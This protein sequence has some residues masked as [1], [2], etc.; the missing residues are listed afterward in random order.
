MGLKTAM[1]HG[2]KV[3][4]KRISKGHIEIVYE[5]IELLQGETPITHCIL[6]NCVDILINS[7]ND[8]ANQEMAT[9]LLDQ[10]NADGRTPLEL[11]AILGRVEIISVLLQF[12]ANVNLANCGGY[13]P[14]HYAAAWGQTQ[15]LKLLIEAKADLS[16]T[17]GIGETPH[18]LALRY[19]Q[20]E[21]I[22]FIDWIEA[23]TNLEF[24]IKRMQERLTES[25]RRPTKEEK[26]LVLN[27]C[28]EKLAW[29]ESATMPTT[30]DFIVQQ[31][32]LEAA[33]NP[34]MEKLLSHYAS[35][36]K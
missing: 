22:D 1:T 30:Q 26:N 27:A 33:L 6:K 20:M 14:A 25:E 16:L 32:L 11:S 29:L 31:E 4:D 18:Q 10:R 12:G 13:T 23:K 9:S 8:E 2:N 19:G 24:T 28:K 21:C 7:L 5:E 34:V 17:N 36:K 3:S 15:I 35:E